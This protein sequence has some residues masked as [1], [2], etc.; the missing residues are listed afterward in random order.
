MFSSHKPGEQGIGFVL[1][2]WLTG[3]WK[4]AQVFSIYLNPFYVMN[5]VSLSSPCLVGEPDQETVLWKQECGGT[6]NPEI[7][8]IGGGFLS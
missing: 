5:T 6:T 7:L 1:I 4:N 2:V 8:P 3:A